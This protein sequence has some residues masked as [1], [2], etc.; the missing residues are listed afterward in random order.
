MLNE[1]ALVDHLPGFKANGS[2]HVVK[3]AQA[4]VQHVKPEVVHLDADAISA[5]ADAIETFNFDSHQA[6][7]IQQSAVALRDSVR[8][9]K[10]AEDK[11]TEAPRVRAAVRAIARQL[12]LHCLATHDIGNDAGLVASNRKYFATAA[13]LVESSVLQ[14]TALLADPMAAHAEASLAFQEARSS[15]AQRKSLQSKQFHAAAKSFDR[16][17][18]AFAQVRKDPLIEATAQQLHA[19]VAETNATPIETNTASATR[20]DV[21]AMIE[22]LNERY[23]DTTLKPIDATFAKNINLVPYH[24]VYYGMAAR[25]LEQTLESSM[26]QLSSLAMEHERVAGA[27]LN[28]LSRTTQLRATQVSRLIETAKTIE[29]RKPRVLPIDAQPSIAEATLALRDIAQNLKD[30]P[31]ELDAAANA[32]MAAHTVASR[33]LAK[34][35]ETTDMSALILGSLSP[36]DPKTPF[37]V[38]LSDAYSKYYSSAARL[39][40]DAVDTNLPRLHDAINTHATYAGRVTESFL[41]SLDGKD[42]PKAAVKMLPESVKDS[43]GKLVKLG[44]NGS[45]QGFS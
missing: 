2:S 38:N 23:G 22:K 28:A 44:R 11:Q 25:L 4:A 10:H 24:Q 42:V 21:H 30:A 43:F 32:H 8:A 12:T 3:P 1:G 5:A 33:M 13:K 36:S 29:S 20:R 41:Q 39:I 7:S 35:G 16:T 15:A 14:P 37:A 6:H 31:I 26:P 9:Y 45:S 27:Y 18:A 19:V 17:A 34:S 40:E